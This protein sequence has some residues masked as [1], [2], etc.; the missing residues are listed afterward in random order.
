MVGLLYKDFVAIKGRI[1][2]IFLSLG[3]ALTV[4]LRM[5]L[6]FDGIDLIIFTLY[7]FF[8]MILF[9][10]LVNKI[11]TAIIATDEGRKRKNY[12]L[13]LPISKQTYVASKYIFLL[14]GF[15]T[16]T[17]ALIL[18]GSFCQIGCV[19]EAME[20]MITQIISLVPIF[21]CLMLFLPSIELPFFIFFG[22]KKGAYLKTGLLIACFFL[23]IVY[24]MFGNLDIFDQISIINLFN[25]LEKHTEIV[26][27]LQVLVPYCSLG[28][29]YVSYRISCLLFLRRE[30]END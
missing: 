6:H 23:I 29:Y 17:S 12:C 28:L 1:Y 26:L 27:I 5:A 2:L 8:T 30:W 24:L 11:E 20:G 3:M 19:D 21:A 16:V 13:G 22:S 25:Y 14:I 4:L 15:F 10:F 18:L 7:F 9:L